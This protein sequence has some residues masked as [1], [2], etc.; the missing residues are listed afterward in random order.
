MKIM[1]LH[2]CHK[3]C[4]AQCTA[5]SMVKSV[6]RHTWKSNKAGMPCVCLLKTHRQL[7]A[8]PEQRLVVCRYAVEGALSSVTRTQLRQDA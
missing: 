1:Y 2:T 6:T 7:H 8:L 3:D 5:L 4:L